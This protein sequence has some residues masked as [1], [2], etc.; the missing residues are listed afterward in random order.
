MEPRNPLL[1]A[2]YAQFLYVVRHD[3]AKVGSTLS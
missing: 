1:L 2:N 3:N